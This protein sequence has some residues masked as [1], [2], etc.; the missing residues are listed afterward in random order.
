VSHK[1]EEGSLALEFRCLAEPAQKEP[2]GMLPSQAALPARRLRKTLSPLI[3]DAARRS[4]AD[5]YRKSFPARA[6]AWMLVLHAM[7]AESSLRQS[8]ARQGSD[9]S[10]RR[11]LGMSE[12][13]VSYSQLARSSTSRPS[14]FFEGLLALLVRLARSRAAR[15]R[16]SGPLASLVLLLDSTFLGLAA[17]TSPWSV[18]GGHA[19]GVRL[20]ATF[21]LPRRVPVA[22]KMTTVG[23]NDAV[24]LSGWDLS[25]LEGRTLVFD[26]G[27]YSHASFRRLRKGGVHFL[28]RLKGQAYYRVSAS[29]ELPEGEPAA[30]EGDTLISDETV[31][32]G[33]PNNRRGAV[34]EGIRLLT[35]RNE[36]GEVHRFLTDR[37]DLSASEVL[38]LYRKRWQIELFFRWLKR[39]L[40]AIEPLGHSPEAVWL[41]IVVAAIVAVLA[42][43]AE[44][45]RPKGVTRVSW[46]RALGPALFRRP[47][48]SG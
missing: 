45:A 30:P 12:G 19:A 25:G 11:S 22:L 14:G 5:R 35:S 47:R 26:L 18:R 36:K 2:L 23:A 8:H 24:A 9:P 27:Y 4:D 20:Q 6:H 46:L 40:G 13:W 1:N 48:F 7:G 32:L 17:K 38:S 3:E 15:R 41:T 44:E 28:T 43:L 34:L 21:D 33:S 10:L 37:H 31:T 16:L 39:Q 42:A 29:R